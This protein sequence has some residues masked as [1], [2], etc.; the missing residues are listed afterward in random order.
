MKAPLVAIWST[1]VSHLSPL[2][3]L[4]V[5]RTNKDYTT[6]YLVHFIPEIP[7]A[8]LGLVFSSDSNPPYMMIVLLLFLAAFVAFVVV[9][10]D[11]EVVAI[12]VATFDVKKYP[13][14]MKY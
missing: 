1:R 5:I 14:K 12:M 6:T 3:I 7:R 4:S 11:V 10:V 8:F 9:L 13:F 2:P